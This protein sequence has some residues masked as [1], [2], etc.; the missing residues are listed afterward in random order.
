MNEA[1]ECSSHFGM[2]E[3]KWLQKLD[4]YAGIVKKRLS[5]A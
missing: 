3:S 5:R 2:F 4:L 1:P